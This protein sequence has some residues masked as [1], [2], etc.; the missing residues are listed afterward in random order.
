MLNLTLYDK[1]ILY[2]LDKQSN[3]SLSELAKKLRRSKPFVLYRMNRLEHEGIITGYNA[4]VDMAALGY[5]SFRIYLKLRQT[6]AK[7]G[8]EFVQCIKKKYPQVW[9]IASVHGKWDFALFVGVKTIN[10]LHVVW[11]GLMLEYKRHIKKYNLSVYAP[12][13][14]FNRRFFLETKEERKVR[15]Y[16]A[17]S[18]VETDQLDWKIIQEYAPSVRKSSLEIG[19]KLGVSADTIRNRIKKMEHKKIICGY[20]IGL[21]LAKLGYESYRIDM[22]LMSTK[23]NMRLFEYCKQHKNIYQINKSIG[24]ANFEMEVI[25]K[26]QQELLELIDELKTEFKEII[27]D[28]DY[29]GFSTY[30]ILNYIPD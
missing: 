13:Y 1:N 4:I 14:N 21:N 6:T 9:T 25:V 20:K 28:V 12:I 22:E 17:G 2:E 3:L 30:H 26:G 11:D 19:K 8:E 24:G 7:E 16:G 15:I 18:L 23:E 5:F 10:E 29:F 27:E